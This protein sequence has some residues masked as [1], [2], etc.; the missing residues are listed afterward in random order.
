MLLRLGNAIKKIKDK[1]LLS[2][3]LQVHSKSHNAK[4]NKLSDFFLVLFDNDA[5]L[6]PIDTICR[7][8]TDFHVT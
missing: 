6:L 2:I 4:G 1:L 3:I 7:A 8:C 5:N